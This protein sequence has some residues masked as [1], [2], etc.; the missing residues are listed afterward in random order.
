MK[1]CVSSK[2]RAALSWCFWGDL[3]CWLSLWLLLFGLADRV[4]A[5]CLPKS[6]LAV[7]RGTVSTWEHA[8]VER[9][10]L[11]REHGQGLGINFGVG[12][13][14]N[15]VTSDVGVVDFLGLAAVVVDL[16]AAED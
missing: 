15:G 1:T 6:L 10:C 3:L 14:G 8:A 12:S 11:R 4:F 2:L 5:D 16:L 9:P 7:G 13:Q